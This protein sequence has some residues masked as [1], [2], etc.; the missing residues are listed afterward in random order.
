MRSPT[1][2]RTRSDTMSM[3]VSSAIACAAWLMCGQC[4]RHRARRRSSCN[5]ACAPLP[6]AHSG[7]TH[8]QTMTW[9]QGNSSMQTEFYHQSLD[10]ETPFRVFLHSGSMHTG[11]EVKGSSVGVMSTATTMRPSINRSTLRDLRHS[12]STG[13]CMCSARSM[14]RSAA[15]RQPSEVVAHRCCWF[16]SC[17]TH[18]RRIEGPG[19]WQDNQGSL[20][21]CAAADHLPGWWPGRSEAQRPWWHNQLCCRRRASAAAGAPPAWSTR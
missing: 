4:Q 18:T 5:T 3:P 21:A 7:S 19:P 14:R 13:G 10:S 20:R 15:A 16:A 6:C 2:S 17:H 9:Q 8:T 1:R 11:A 12:C